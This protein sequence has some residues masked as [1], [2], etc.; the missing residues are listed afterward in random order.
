MCGVR[1]IACVRYSSVFGALRW[2]GFGLEGFFLSTCT[3]VCFC[4]LFVGRLLL[5][6]SFVR[7]LPEDDCCKSKH[8]ALVLYSIIQGESLVGGPKLLSIKN[9]VIE[10]MT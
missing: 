3:S 5:L 2:R 8:V 10:I 6:F 4:F 7:W 9:Y 1:K